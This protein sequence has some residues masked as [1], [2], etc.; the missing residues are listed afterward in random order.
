MRR[1]FLLA[2]LIGPVLAFFDV[3]WG[4]GGFE[5]A[6]I[7]PRPK[8]NREAIVQIYEAR[9]CRWRGLLS[10]HT[11]V[12]V[13]KPFAKYY[14]IYHIND[15]KRDGDYLDIFKG[16]ADMHWFGNKP[17]LIYELKGPAAESLITQI[18]KAAI[19][20]PYRNQFNFLPGPNANT[21]I[22]Y[23][24][25]SIPGLHFTMSPNSLGKDYFTDG[26]FFARTTSDSAYQ[27]SFKGLVGM[28]LGGEEGYQLSIGG[29]SFG[30][31]LAE[32]AVTLPGVGRCQF[33]KTSQ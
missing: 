14:T 24:A 18:D 33:S 17:N 29:L 8:S 1:I 16:T 22:A 28:T 32:K 7:A 9:D 2:L 19:S 4:E 20:Y 21:F 10:M 25:R 26:G 12:A 5:S 11:W 23:L 31:S 3:D 27:L 15:A 13:K 30:V 6:G